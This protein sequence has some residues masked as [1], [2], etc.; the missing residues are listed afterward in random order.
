MRVRRNVELTFIVAIAVLLF[1]YF[2]FFNLSSNLRTYGFH[3][4]DAIVD[5]GYSTDAEHPTKLMLLANEERMG[6]VV[7]DGKGLG[8]WAH[9]PIV[10]ILE[11]PQDG[12]FASV[13]L[14]ILKDWGE[15]SYT[16]KHVF[17]SAY[18][19]I[20]ERPT[21]PNGENFYVHADYFDIGGRTLVYAHAMSDEDVFGEEH[22]I[23]HLQEQLG[24]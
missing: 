12:E 18:I 14:P 8:V 9:D 22:V 5:E 20:G 24:L 2:F 4:R 11:N 1:A 10:S 17:A 21:V 7:L 23:A 16:E 3:E 6:I 15:Q 13:Y 19:E